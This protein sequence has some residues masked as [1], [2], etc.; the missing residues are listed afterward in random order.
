MP[1]PKTAPSLAKVVGHNLQRLREAKGLTQD[2]LAEKTKLHRVT[3]AQI[4]AAR[5]PSVR[6]SSLEVI[7]TALG[8]KLDAFFVSSSEGRAPDSS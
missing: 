8:E 5:Y 2:Q 1:R 4:E 7:A 6:T 3:I